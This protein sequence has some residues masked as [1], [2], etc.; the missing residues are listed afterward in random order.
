MRTLAAIILFTMAIPGLSRAQ[1]GTWVWMN[2]DTTLTNNQTVYGTMGVPDTNNTPDGS[3]DSPN[4]TDLDGNFWVMVGPGGNGNVMWKYNPPTNTWTWVNGPHAVNNAP[5][6][7]GVKGVPSPSNIPCARAWGCISWTDNNNDL[8]L[9]G[10]QGND[11]QGRYGA[12]ND[13]WRYNISNNQWT[14]MSGSDSAN[15]RGNYG[16]LQMAS[17]S[18]MP[19]ARFETNSGWVDC[20]NCLWLFGGYGAVD[21]NATQLNDMWRYDITNNMWTWMKGD[22]GANPTYNYGTLGV[23]AASNLPRGRS[24]YT[25][26]KDE[27]GN[28]YIWSGL[29]DGIVSDVWKFNPL[30]NNWT[31]VSGPVLPR[32]SGDYVQYCIDSG[33]PM[34]RFESRTAQVIGATNVF[35]GFGGSYNCFCFGNTLSDLWTFNAQTYKWKWLAGTTVIDAGPGRYGTRGVPAAANYPPARMG[36]FVWIDT[37]GAIWMMGGLVGYGG[38]GGY[39]RNDLWKFIPDTSCLDGPLSK[40]VTIHSS[41]YQISGSTI[42]AGDTLLLTLVG[43]G[44][45]QVTPAASLV[46]IDSTADSAHIYVIPD[47]TSTYTITG[48]SYCTNAFNQQFTVTVSNIAVVISAS[49]LVI[50]AGDSVK[51]CARSGFAHYS[52]GHSDT[53][54]CVEI[55]Q[56]GSYQVTVTDANGCQAVSNTL[57]VVVNSPPVVLVT[58]NHDTLTVNNAGTQQWYLNNNLMPGDTAKMLV[59]TQPGNY[60]VQVTDSNGC[61]ATSSIQKIVLG[62]N[63]I[64]G[65]GIYLYPNPATNT[66][67]LQLTG[68]GANYSAQIIDIT[69]RVVQPLFSHQQISTFN[70]STAGLGTGVYFVHVS[71]DDGNVAIIKLVKE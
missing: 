48:T 42:C 10:G 36:Q 20:H 28:F 37:A 11:A 12:L 38:T 44:Q 66:C 53:T 61:S 65:T 62:V 43:I 58:V 60:T 45:P 6:V 27:D 35:V 54:S 4:W 32:D 50:C 71:D 51:L 8:W 55:T 23:E 56:P 5:A 68:T 19:G 7:F 21:G 64:A 47:T 15:R 40:P 14:W 63:E 57:T 25:R 49:S 3:Y 16:S 52:W 26:W 67:S 69:G 59:A 24:C 41:Y 29:A 46:W 9:F 30:T 13:L 17:P 18:N 70:F 2:G 31:W 34:A 33:I 39:T 22:S 1:S